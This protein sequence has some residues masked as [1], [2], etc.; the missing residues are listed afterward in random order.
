MRRSLTKEQAFLCNRIGILVCDAAAIAFLFAGLR[1]FDYWFGGF[2]LALWFGLGLFN[3]AEHSSLWLLMHKRNSFLR[4]YAALALSFF[5]IDQSGQMLHLWFSPLYNGWG[6][7]LVYLLFLPLGGLALVEVLHSFPRDARFSLLVAAGTLI[8]A[9]FIG[10][11]PST[12]LR[13]WVYLGAPFFAFCNFIFFG[14][15]VF[16]WLGSLL[17]AA[18]PLALYRALALH[19]KV[20]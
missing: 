11:V 8:V 18:V 3:Y 9:A 19:W 16:A 1:G 12:H 6:A 17:F 2:V 4:F 13:E 7:L 20:K 5:M 15:P 10:F 14:L